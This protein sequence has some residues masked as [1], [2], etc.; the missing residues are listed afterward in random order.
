MAENE[1]LAPASA[2]RAARRPSSVK[3]RERSSP[4]LAR[5]VVVPSVGQV[6][7]RPT[8]PFFS[9]PT[10][11]HPHVW[12]PSDSYRRR[13]RPNDSVANDRSLPTIISCALFPDRPSL[14]FTGVA[15]VRLDATEVE[16]SSVQAGTRAMKTTRSSSLRL[17]NSTRAKTPPTG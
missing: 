4:C 2:H 7:R 8:P 15:T 6:N 10:D 5:N 16:A 14:V 13:S 11:P 3:H 1:G 12:S 17:T 9:H